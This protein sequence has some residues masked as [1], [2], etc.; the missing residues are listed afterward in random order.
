MEKGVSAVIVWAVNDG[1]VMK[2][3]EKELKVEGSMISFYGD[4]SSVLTKKLGLELT[5]SRVME[6]LRHVRY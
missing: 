6:S 4:P 2:A 5:D 1:A 3:W